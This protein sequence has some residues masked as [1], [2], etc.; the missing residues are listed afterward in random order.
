MREIKFRAWDGEQM[1]H[2]PLVGIGVAEWGLYEML[3]HPQIWKVMQ[4][5]G[6]H[7]KNGREIYESDIVR[8]GQSYTSLAQV[9]YQAPSFVMKE[10]PSHKTWYEFILAA[11][12]NQ[13]CEIVGNIYENPELLRG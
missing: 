11:S 9:V 13:F 1:Y 6:L 12:E 10:K 7:D 2:H 4:F 5:T 8:T 3:N